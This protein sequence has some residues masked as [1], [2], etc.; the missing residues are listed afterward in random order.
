[1]EKH[2]YLDIT[3]HKVAFAVKIN[4]IEL[5]V[6]RFHQLPSKRLSINQ[7]VFSGENEVSVNISINPHWT[8]PLNEQSFKMELIEYTGTKGNF[9]PRTLREL[10]WRYIE[11][12]TRFP[13]NIHE[14]FELDLPYGDWLWRKG[15]ALTEETLPLESLKK[16]ITTL[17]GHLAAKE[18]AA[19]E[20][21]LQVKAT[22]LARAYSIPFSERLSDQRSFFQ[23][24]LFTDSKWGMEPLDFGRMRVLFHAGGKLL[25]VVNETGK[26]FLASLPLE[27]ATFSLPLRVCYYNDAWVL[28]R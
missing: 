13:V 6:S 4:G 24:E 1:M 14:L 5:V 9:A 11:D 28:C 16:F 12:E 8:E 23:S 17:H 22:E 19:L 18:Y 20:P 2:I 15:T 27:E 10:S 26:P 21:F 3:N 25:E 7:W